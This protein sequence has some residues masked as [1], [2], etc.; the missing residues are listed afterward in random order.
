MVL[1]DSTLPPEVATDIIRKAKQ[2]DID[3]KVLEGIKKTRYLQSRP[4]VIKAG[5][6]H[7][8][9][10]FAQNPSDHGHFANMLRISPTVFEVLLHLIKE[11]PVFSNNS[12]VP[13]KPVKVQLAITLY[14][15]GRYGNGA[16][17]EDI[18]QIAGSSE[19]VENLNIITH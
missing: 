9:W 19:G 7:L 17:L 6:F 3:L 5:N 14:R 4:S 10:S 16:S 2:L 1:R 11:H 8:A 13:Q 12:N 15:M 18:A